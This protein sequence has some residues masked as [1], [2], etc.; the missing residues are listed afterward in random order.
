ML[1]AGAP[2]RPWTP[3][4][5]GCIPCPLVSSSPWSGQWNETLKSCWRLVFS[6]C[7]QL[8]WARLC[9]LRSCSQELMFCRG[10]HFGPILRD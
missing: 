8:L 7:G 4:H 6:G 10:R 2:V 5:A 3:P 9:V 1:D